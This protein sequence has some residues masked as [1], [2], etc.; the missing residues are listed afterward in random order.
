ML[1]LTRSTL[2]ALLECRLRNIAALLSRDLPF[3]SSERLLQYVQLGYMKGFKEL[4]E[5]RS[6]ACSLHTINKNG[7]DMQQVEKLLDDPNLSN[8]H[9][10]IPLAMLADI[11]RQQ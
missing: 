2:D 1:T 4:L 5:L 6:L 10:L 7:F 9:R 8:D 3:I 11:L